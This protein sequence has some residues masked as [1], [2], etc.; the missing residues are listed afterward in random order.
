MD[1]YSEPNETTYAAIKDA[2]NEDKL[3]GPFETVEE[4]MKSLYE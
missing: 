2:E 1:N 4:F 3:Y